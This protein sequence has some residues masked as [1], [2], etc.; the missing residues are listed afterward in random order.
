M[1]SRMYLTGLWARYNLSRPNHHKEKHVNASGLTLIKPGCGNSS[2]NAVLMLREN[3]NLADAP[4]S[5]KPIEHKKRY[6]I[7]S[8]AIENHDESDIIISYPNLIVH[9]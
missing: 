8:S 4:R 1:K 2:Y 7:I 9:Q 6:V 5:T 3:K